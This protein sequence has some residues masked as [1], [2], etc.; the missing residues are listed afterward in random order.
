MIAPLSH[1]SAR[2][3]LVIAVVPPQ[4]SLYWIVTTR[5]RSQAI[6]S[7]ARSMSCFVLLCQLPPEA[8]CAGAMHVVGGV[9]PT[10][11]SSSDTA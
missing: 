8:G 10:C 9:V 2:A 3:E 1:A 11:F 4:L 5:V 7:T 6:A